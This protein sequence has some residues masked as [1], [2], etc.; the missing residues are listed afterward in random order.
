MAP[1]VV[2]TTLGVDVGGVVTASLSVRRR[3]WVTLLS[4][5]SYLRGVQC[6]AR[7]LRS[8]GSR[9]ELVVMVT[10]SVGDESMDALRAEQCSIRVIEYVRV[11]SEAR[12]AYA[13][14][15]FA[16]C[17]TKLSAWSWVEYEQLAYLDADMLPLA[18]MDELLD[19]DVPAGVPLLAV[20]ECACR[21]RVMR[22]H[23]PYAAAVPTVPASG[24][25]SRLVRRYFNAGL[26]VFRPSLDEHGA[27]LREMAQSDAAVLPFAEQDLL[28]RRYAS[29][30]LP[31]S[32][33]YNSTKAVWLNHR[34]TGARA[35]EGPRALSDGSVAEEVRAFDLDMRRVR[36]LHFTMAKPWQLRDPL[37][38][39]FGAI[40]QLWWDAFLKGARAS[41]GGVGTLN[42]V[43][44]VL[45][46]RAK[47]ARAPAAAAAR[48]QSHTAGG[49]ELAGLSSSDEPDSDADADGA[50]RA[51]SASSRAP[52]ADAAA[53]EPSDG[54]AELAVL[55]SERWCLVPDHP[56]GHLRVPEVAV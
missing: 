3:A 50:D 19:V 56:A 34:R 51:S 6:L 44:M 1:V 42:K 47:A 31:L 21:Q 32:V 55:E 23:C 24:A 52:M 27:L 45:A 4:T 9:Y 14:A 43:C 5:D 16:D 8:V 35:A 17:W 30:W 12:A 2:T 26:L 41:K 40:N 22:A 37:N 53:A 15:H 20:P 33:H 29:R 46:L 36:N 18:N 10:G 13:C 38:R 11:P 7:A 39:G 48:E 28:N 54:A 49:P 25:P